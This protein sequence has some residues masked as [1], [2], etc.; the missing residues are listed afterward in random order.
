MQP[1]VERTH[2]D[3]T[4]HCEVCPV[5]I[6]WRIIWWKVTP[7]KRWL[8]WRICESTL[9][10]LNSKT[11]LWFAGMYSANKGKYPSIYA[12]KPGLITT[13]WTRWDTRATSRGPPARPPPHRLA[14]SWIDRKKS[15]CLWKIS[16]SL[17]WSLIRDFAEEKWNIYLFNKYFIKN[18]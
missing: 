7:Q 14:T 3:Y 13:P 17:L 9:W 12:R 11:S 15:K 18:L 1:M 4:E 5:E 16:K 6:D 10:L 2:S 8:M